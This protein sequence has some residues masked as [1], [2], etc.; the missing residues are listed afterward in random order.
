MDVKNFGYRIWRTAGGWAWSAF[1]LSGAVV[2]QG[3]ARDRAIAAACVIR[4]LSRQAPAE[5]HRP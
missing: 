1:D 4:A 2:E 3:A 5:P